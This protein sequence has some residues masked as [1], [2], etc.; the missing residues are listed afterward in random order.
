MVNV[1]MSVWAGFEK[2]FPPCSFGDP[3]GVAIG[4]ASV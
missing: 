1:L 3:W 4:V 2:S